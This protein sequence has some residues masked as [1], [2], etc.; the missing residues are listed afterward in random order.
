MVALDDR[1][2]VF[3]ERSLCI[4]CGRTGH[5]G[6]HCRSRKCFN[7]GSKHHTSL[8]DK[9]KLDK[10][11]ESEKVGKPVLNCYSGSPEG[12][13]LPA[14][15]P[16]KIRNKEMWAY[17]DT[18]SARNFVSREAAKLLN[19]KPKGHESREIVTLNGVTQQSMPIYEVE[20]SSLDGKACEKVD[21]TGS[22]LPDFT[23]VRRPN[24][25]SLK[26][27]YEHA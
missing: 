12:N 5:R 26:L 27:K 2:K 19:L 3:V 21:V 25:P 18:G 20:I 10:E 4:N 8:C 9:S 24:I 13:S 7:C 15:I 22:R 17:L 11:K 23:T 1:K 6:Y 16:V 14:I